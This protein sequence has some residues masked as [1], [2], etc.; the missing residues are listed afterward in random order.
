MLPGGG[1]GV[2]GLDYL[3]NGLLAIPW[4]DLGCYLVLLVAPELLALELNLSPVTQREVLQVQKNRKIYYFN[5]H[6]RTYLYPV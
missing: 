6:C 1:V 2:G 3:E 4:E 5:A